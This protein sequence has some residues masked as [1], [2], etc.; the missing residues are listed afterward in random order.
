[1]GL[2]KFYT[3]MLL[4]FSNSLFFYF[5]SVFSNFLLYLRVKD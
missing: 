5:F 1:M 2:K 4:I 3:K